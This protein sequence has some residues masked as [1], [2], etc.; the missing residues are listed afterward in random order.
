NNDKGASKTSAKS[1][2]SIDIEI[3]EKQVRERRKEQ[4][5]RTKAQEGRR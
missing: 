1:N 3:Q 5:K 2:E 4:K